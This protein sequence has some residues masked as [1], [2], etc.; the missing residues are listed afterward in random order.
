MAL[1]GLKAQILDVE[2]I[3]DV[4]HLECRPAK[5]CGEIDPVGHGD[6]GDIPPLEFL[7]QV[8]RNP[9]AARQAIE[10]MHHDGR[11][12]GNLARPHHHRKTACYVRLARS[13]RSSAATAP[14]LR[15]IMK[16]SGAPGR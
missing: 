3:P 6:E 15:P 13:P 11:H 9:D 10:L 16:P 12:A 7:D 4:L 1:A 8:V 2:L 14:A 5:G